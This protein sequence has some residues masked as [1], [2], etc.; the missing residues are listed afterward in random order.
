MVAGIAIHTLLGVDE[1]H[2]FAFVEAV[3]RTNDNA[4]C[5]LAVKTRFSD[6]VSHGR[7][8]KQDLDWGYK[9]Q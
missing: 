6:N 1:Q 5:L 8:P 4:I 3:A 9:L 7:L 2:R